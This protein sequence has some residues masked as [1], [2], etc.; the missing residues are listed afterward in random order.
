[1]GRHRIRTMSDMSGESISAQAKMLIP[2]QVEIPSLCVYVCVCVCA[3]ICILLIWSKTLHLSAIGFTAIPGPCPDS[4]HS[5][6]VIRLHPHWNKMWTHST[7]KG[8]FRILVM[9]PFIY[10]S[11]VKGTCGY[12][13][14]VS[15]S[16]MK[17]FVGR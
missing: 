8:W 9:M 1:M 2:E 11:R 12:H 4:A 17:E 10:L 15:A 5:Y 16:S 13:C 14:Y 3:S 6:K 7:L